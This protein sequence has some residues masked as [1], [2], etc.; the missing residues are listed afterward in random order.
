MSIL[1]LDT[2]SEFLKRVDGPGQIVSTT[3]KYRTPVA[4]NNAISPLPSV[5]Q[6]SSGIPIIDTGMDM[7]GGVICAFGMGLIGAALVLRRYLA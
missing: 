5:R 1:G 7:G 6:R 2:E 3:S 4:R